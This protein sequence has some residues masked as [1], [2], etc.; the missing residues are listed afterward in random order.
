MKSSNILLD[1]NFEPRVSDFGLARIISACETHVSTDIA[2]TFGYIPPE[3]GMTM[4]SSAKGDVYSFGVV[5]LELLT[6]RPPTGQEEGEGGGNL[7]GWVR[8]MIAHGKE[9]EL[10]DPCLPVSSLWREQMACVLAIARDCTA[11]E[12][13]KRPSMLEVVKGLKMAQ[14]MECGPLVVTVTREV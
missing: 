7:V 4:K 13:W 14:T 1:E 5:M 6:G 12:P 2:G 11:D 9:N 10:F 3:Y 8:W